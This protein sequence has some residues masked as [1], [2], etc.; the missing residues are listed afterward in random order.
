M[1]VAYLFIFSFLFLACYS[2]NTN[3]GTIDSLKRLENK[4]QGI[5]K[6]DLYNRL[7]LLYFTDADDIDSSLRYA[8]KALALSK[9]LNYKKGLALGY[10]SLG[11][12]INMTDHDSAIKVFSAGMQ[13]LNAKKKREEKNESRSPEN[14][15]VELTKM[16]ADLF[17]ETGVAYQRKFNLSRAAENYLQASK[18]YE[19]AQK[20]NTNAFVDIMK[21]FGSWKGGELTIPQA[22]D[23]KNAHPDDKRVL[24]SFRLGADI[25]GGIRWSCLQLGD[26]FINIREFREALIYLKKAETNAEQTGGK[27]SHVKILLSIGNLYY[28]NGQFDS[29]VI[30]YKKLCRR[31]EELH[32]LQASVEG[33]T[34]LGNAFKAKGDYLKA[35]EAYEKVN[36]YLQPLND[37]TYKTNSLY[38]SMPAQLVTNMVFHFRTAINLQLIGDMYSTMGRDDEARRNYNNAISLLDKVL[39]NANN[40]MDT[41]R[42]VNVNWSLA[43]LYVRINEYKKAI[44]K[45]TGILPY[46][47]K[48]LPAEEQLKLSN[49]IQ[50]A[51]EKNGDLAGAYKF[52]KKHIALKDSLFG[53][54]NSNN[55][56]QLQKRFEVEKKDADIIILNKAQEVQAAELE[57]QKLVRNVFIAGSVLL[58]LLAFVIFRSLVQNRKAKKI[59]ESQKELV[60][61]K[62]KE[63]TDSITYAKRLQEAIL[64]PLD[65]IKTTLPGSFVLYRP[66]D[67]VAGDFYWMEIIQPEVTSTREELPTAPAGSVLIAA[68]DCTGHG[69][70]GAL[71]SVVCSNALNRAVKEF[72]IS[73]PGEV[74]DKTRNLVIETFE[75]SGAEVKDGMDIS[76]LSISQKQNSG[77]FSVK[78]AGANNPLWYVENNEL[79][80][81]T[82]NK[83]PIGKF[84]Q[85]T[86]FQTHHFELP[87]GTTLFL[88][89]D[90][91]ADQFGGPKGKKFKYKQLEKLVIENISSPPEYL[92]EILSR[93]FEAWKINTEQVDDV[94]II[95]IRL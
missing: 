5:S 85:P 58:L 27:E 57:T 23:F 82:A 24:T 28:R 20:E 44:Q 26:L 52:Y 69:V 87:P 49:D 4:T 70:P 74:L 62:N 81:I 77:K 89:T 8:G 88:F 48:V 80:E 42:V 12:A 91:Y 34:K 3:P 17:F 37:G 67:I 61:E 47:E 84:H 93:E 38:S 16:L 18:L 43:N 65:L 13:A 7:A 53:Q 41:L 31:A 33:A 11:R 35:L 86:P 73:D 94:C 55:I 75:K 6:A 78:W 71:V 92:K 59:I 10:H 29:S 22:I 83:Q 36:T 32:M 30:Y 2:Q 76:L 54:Q 63:I 19:N 25:L 90:G 72:G 21:E 50:T 66:K 56:N 60:E 39:V 15:S 14:S 9:Q 40:S 95:G 64:P 1:R 51:Y 79:K 68:A 46:Y 45:F